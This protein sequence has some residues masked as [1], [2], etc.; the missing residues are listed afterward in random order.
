MA[1]GC[2]GSSFALAVIAPIAT[3]LSRLA[4][5][6]DQMEP[7]PPPPENPWPS[8]GML[9][10]EKEAEGPFERGWSE[11]EQAE[12]KASIARAFQYIDHK[13]GDKVGDSPLSQRTSSSQKD[14]L[15]PRPRSS[16][17]QVVEEPDN[18]EDE[19][20]SARKV[21][22]WYFNGMIPD[23]QKD[24][25]FEYQSSIGRD[26]FEPDPLRPT[27]EFFG[28]FRIDYQHH[29]LT[30]ENWN[31]AV[32]SNLDRGGM[33][34][35]IVGL[36]HTYD[37]A[38][39]SV[40]LGDSNRLDGSYGLVSG[41]Y[42]FAKGRGAVITGGQKNI[43]SGVY[44]TVAGGYQNNATGM[45]AS[46]RGGENNL[47]SGQ[48]SMVSGGLTNIAG[49]SESTVTAGYNN[50]VLGNISS[51]NGGVNNTIHEWNISATVEGGFGAGSDIVTGPPEIAI[52]TAENTDNPSGLAAVAEDCAACGEELLR[53]EEKT[54]EGRVHNAGHFHHM[55]GGTPEVRRRR[56]APTVLNKMGAVQDSME[57]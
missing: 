18:E 51:I 7:P 4:T 24:L 33:G 42:N 15:H 10:R 45:F 43:A 37:R 8:A 9:R 57:D 3:A 52:E 28:P 26:G 41:R 53:T 29:T 32:S 39:N 54:A 6:Q 1:P 11:Q 13:I 48:F 31:L 36:N 44:S 47:A 12:S 49:G 22:S 55:G 35:L 38:R 27:S 19:N 40:L 14:L 56:S 5:D 20:P 16:Q 23:P 17:L 2:H 34:N 30:L 50:R 21:P 46:V 25:K